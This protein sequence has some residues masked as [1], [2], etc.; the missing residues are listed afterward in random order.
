MYVSSILKEFEKSGSC[1]R[2]FEVLRMDAWIILFFC[3][4]LAK[5]QGVATVDVNILVF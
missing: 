5:H 2:R 3:P 4:P 1:G